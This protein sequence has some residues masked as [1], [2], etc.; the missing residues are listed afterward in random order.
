M[1]TKRASTKLI[2]NKRLVDWVCQR[3]GPFVVYMR[4]QVTK[5]TDT[6]NIPQVTQNIFSNCSCPQNKANSTKRLKSTKPI[7]KPK[8]TRHFFLLSVFPCSPHAAEVAGGYGDPS[9]GADGLLLPGLAALRLRWAELGDAEGGWRE[10][11]GVKWGGF[12]E[13]LGKREEETMVVWKIVFF[14]QNIACRAA[15][16]GGDLPDY[17]LCATG[18][19]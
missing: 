12:G 5:P 6:L 14:T 8:T 3:F 13:D 16:F 19:S 18:C 15:D 2:F 4:E 11:G 9:S 1:M 17:F 10:G 7:L